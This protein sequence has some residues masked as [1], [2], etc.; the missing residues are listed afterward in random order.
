MSAAF[1]SNSQYKIPQV[2]E[3]LLLKYN[4]S[5][6]RY[7]SYPTAPMWTE[8]YDAQAYG[9]TLRETNRPGENR[10]PISLYVHLPFCEHRCLFCG[11]NVVITQQREQA[12]KYLGYLFREID[13]LSRL[14]D[15]SRPVVQYHWGGGTPTYLS[16]EQ[17][18]RLFRYTAERFQLAPDVEIS[19]EVDPRV[20]TF[21]QVQ[22]LR[23]LGFNRVSMGVQDFAPEV[24]EAVKRIQP[25][26]MTADLLNEC[27]RLGFEGTNLDL[28]YGLPH[29]TPE[30]FA[31]TV[32]A[33]LQLNPDRLALYNYAHVPW[34]SP[35]QR[36]IDE[37]T[38]PTGA[39][40]FK[41]FQH[42][43]AR[44]TDAGYWYIG[45]DHFAKPEDELSKALQGGTLHR[46][47]MGYTTRAGTEL[48]G[49][50]V[51]SISGLRAVYAQNLKK[52]STYYAAI[53]EGMLPTWRGFSLSEQDLLRRDI[54]QTVLCQGRLNFD[55]IEQRHGVVFEESFQDALAKLRQG[56]TEDG[57]LDWQDRG[58]VLT[59]LGRV[60]SRN[61]AMPFDAYLGRPSE[62]SKHG[63]PLFSKTL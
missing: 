26:E 51:S 24:Q 47:F 38:L 54:I 1:A 44:F 12:E 35:H 7:T 52:L 43:N 28:I 40:K 36:L 46:N 2:P 22:V 32:E 34:M 16:E 33:I 49:L 5:G 3:A 58:F 18:A 29:Q 13:H 19:I 31:E 62:E 20:T 42:A 41:I 55:S 27:R 53:D 57:L 6:P 11:C 15:T 14:I 25:V 45:M 37:T 17:I 63:Q 61:V 48:L 8:R 30:S 9:N 60:F 39:T 10:M 56:P 21:G 23:E 4:I 59:P 50:G